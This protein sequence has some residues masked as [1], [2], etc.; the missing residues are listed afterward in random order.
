MS[1]GTRPQAARAAPLSYE[2]REPVAPVPWRA[3]AAALTGVIVFA[4]MCTFSF[5]G[6]LNILWEARSAGGR[7]DA[8]V[9]AL[10]TLLVVV[11]LGMGAAGIASFKGL[12]GRRRKIVYV[13]RGLADPE[14][15]PGVAP[16]AESSAGPRVLNYQRRQA[17]VPMR[18][19]IGVLALCATYGTLAIGMGIL[20][21]AAAIGIVMAWIPD[22]RNPVAWPER[23]AASVG[24]LLGTIFCGLWVWLFLSQIRAAVRRLHPRWRGR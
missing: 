14:R 6:A 4:T 20:G 5:V 1:R 10:V 21:F 19:W 18:V 22:S 12:D 7:F 11:G 2:T 8:G 9:V 3:T 23:T 17:G 15:A 13:R 16:A 24:S